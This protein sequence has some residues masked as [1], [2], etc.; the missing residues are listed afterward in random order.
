MLIPDGLFPYMRTSSG[1][2]FNL[3]GFG[4]YTSGKA[5]RL[6]S[7][8]LKPGPHQLPLFDGDLASI[9][10]PPRLGA[11]TPAWAPFGPAVKS[12]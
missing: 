4:F 6:K 5:H 10:K 2:D 9:R 12:D 3:C 11:P 8:L 7:V 1:T